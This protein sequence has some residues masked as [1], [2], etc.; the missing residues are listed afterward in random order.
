MSLVSTEVVENR[1]KNL[2]IETEKR[3][4]EEFS[5]YQHRSRHEK[6]HQELINFSYQLYLLPQHQLQYLIIVVRKCADFL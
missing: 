3:R 1:L 5:N 2:L 6:Q 4:K